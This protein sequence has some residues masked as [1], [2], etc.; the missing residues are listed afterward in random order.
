MTTTEITRQ[1]SRQVGRSLNRLEA[2]AK[3]TGRAE[4]IHNLVLP[5]MLYGKIFRSTLAHGRIVSIDVSAA[6]DMEGVYGVYT[7]QDILRVIPDPYFG[8]AFHDQPILALDKVR[9]V[10]E[11]VA[12]VL[13]ADPHI[14]EEATHLIVA[15]YEELPA[16]FNEVEA[17]SSDVLVHDMLKPAGT[18]PDLKHLVGRKGTNVALD[19]QL[20]SGDVEA[21]FAA[22]EHVFEDTFTTQQV[23]HTP[24]EPMVSLAEPGDGTITIH[25]ASQSPSFVRIEIARLLGWAENRVRVRTA[26]LGGGFGAKLYIK[27][28]ALVT[29]LALLARR[30]VKVALTMEE[31]FFTITKHATTFR[32]KTAVSA[33]GRITGRKCDVW[34]NGGAYADIGPRVTQKSGFTASGPY[35]IENVSIDSYAVYTNLPPAGAF[36][37]FGIP[38]MVWAY[39]SHADMIARA[40]KIDPVEFR[41]RNILREGRPHATG[42]PMRDAALDLVLERVAARMNWTAPFERGA[43]TLRRGRGIGIGFKALVAPTTSVAMVSLAGDGS[44]TVYSSTVD[45]GQ[46]SDTAIA[47]MAGD[48]LGI[49]AEKI[50]VIRPDTDVTPYDMAT[51]GSRSTFHMGHAVRLAAEDALVKLRGLAD[52]LGMPADAPLAAGELLRRKYGMQA[53]NI[54][55]VGSFIPSYTK[56]EHETGQSENITPNWMVGG[57]GVEVEVDTETGHFRLIRF[58]NVVDCG[59]PINPKVVDTQISGA[60]IMQLGITMFERMEFDEVGQLRNASFAEYKIPGIHDIPSTIGRETVDSY[61]H[62][63]PFGAKGV[64]ESST[65]GVASAIAEAIEDAVGVRL[66]SLP[67]TPEAVYRALCAAKHEPMP[68]E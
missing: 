66:K 67:L 24:L 61:Q 41:R 21:A 57:C 53:G 17:A 68:E 62:N 56:P 1:V 58:E 37:G 35:D 2:R 52:E 26:L 19:F 5:R 42:T 29:A 12:V 30:P 6:R 3:V 38:Q 60:A 39:E 9:Y 43:G 40:L 36:R 45:M 65:F 8:P 51:L 23:M 59:T 14:A 44:C 16:V 55:G 50:K 64:G 31:Q 4:Y 46:A 11:P 25:T 7:A 63:G 28:E 49:A 32:M 15:E 47:L 34:W 18:F 10:G 20:R 48:V 33:G 54:V 27:L 13:A 22:A